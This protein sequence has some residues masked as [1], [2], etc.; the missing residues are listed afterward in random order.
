MNVTFYNTASSPETVVK[1]LSTGVSLEGIPILPFDMLNPLLR[2]RYNSMPQFNYAYIADTGRYYYVTNKTSIAQGVWEIHLA[3]DPLMSFATEIKA[4]TLYVLRNENDYNSMLEN[5]AITNQANIN[6]EMNYTADQSVLSESTFL[7]GK[8]YPWKSYVS[9][10]T[11]FD[12]FNENAPPNFVIAIAANA[13]HRAA[14]STQLHYYPPTGLVYAFTNLA[15]LKDFLDYLWVSSSTPMFGTGIETSEIIK[16][17]YYWPIVPDYEHLT[18]IDFID[19]RRT[20]LDTTIVDSF[21]T[22]IWGANQDGNPL[23]YVGTADFY[24]PNLINIADTVIKTFWTISLTDYTTPETRFTGSSPHTRYRLKLNPFPEVEIDPGYFR[25]PDGTLEDYLGVLVEADYRSGQAYLYITRYTDDTKNYY[26]EMLVSNANLKVTI[27]FVS[28]QGV[29]ITLSEIANGVSSLTML[30]TNLKK[31]G[32]GAVSDIYSSIDESMS[33]HLHGNDVISGG[34]V[35]TAIQDTKPILRIEYSD[36]TDVAAG[37]KAIPLCETRQLSTLS[38]LTICDDVK[39][40][41][42]STA[43]PEELNSIKQSLESGVIL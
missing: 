21:V 15:N 43:L 4:N 23:N 17:F 35:G 27:P 1:T 22:K 40:N 5:N 36:Y 38:G 37:V 8:F 14:D 3:C 31:Q 6:V 26:D 18:R 41:G 19:L 33:K 7:G 16:D 29:A 9:N 24:S 32:T 39:L 12:T 10:I 2:V 11:A 34:S 25:K 20:W 13:M 28:Y 30:S 42:L